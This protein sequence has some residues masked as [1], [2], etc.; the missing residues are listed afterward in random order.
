MRAG[1]VI[2]TLLV[3]TGGCSAVL[4]PNPVEVRISNASAVAFDNVVV[5]FPDGEEAYGS[6]LAHRDSDYRAVERAYRYAYVE[7]M[8][9]GQKLVLQPIDYVGESLLP[10][11]RYSYVLDVASDGRLTLT[12][13]RDD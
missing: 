12:L 13:V 5:G 6:I 10:E 1:I 9:G 4:P 8:V 2:L 7:A 11:G 3:A